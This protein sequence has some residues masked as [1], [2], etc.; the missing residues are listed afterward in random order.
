MDAIS[1]RQVQC[2]YC[3]EWIELQLDVSAGEQAYVEDCSVCCRPI[4]VRL[5]GSGDEWRAQVQRDD[6]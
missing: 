6:D 5:V 2:P 3:G 4:E 1:F